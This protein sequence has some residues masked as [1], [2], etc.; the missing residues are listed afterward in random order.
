MTGGEKFPWYIFT[1]TQ[2]LDRAIVFD[3]TS[4]TFHELSGMNNARSGHGSTVLGRKLYVFGGTLPKY[5]HERYGILEILNFADSFRGLWSKIVVSEA[6]NRE[7]FMFCS[8]NDSELLVMGGYR[9]RYYC[10]R[11]WLSDVEIIRTQSVSR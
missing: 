11:T 4:K 5:H 8:L 3:T 10:A 2:W 1:H 6:C 7:K 9:I